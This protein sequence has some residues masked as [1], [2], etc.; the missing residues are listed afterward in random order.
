MIELPGGFADP[1]EDPET[2][3]RREL[4]EETGYEP[5][6][7]VYVGAIHKE[8]YTHLKVHYFIAY[9]CKKVAETEHEPTEYIEVKK[10]SIGDFLE[11]ARGGGT[12]NTEGVLMA[13][14]ILKDIQK[15]QERV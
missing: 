5:A 13:Y 10:M 2:A 12:T 11:V 9:D 3:A 4:L 15:Q 14:D 1:G 8:A 6:K 7:I